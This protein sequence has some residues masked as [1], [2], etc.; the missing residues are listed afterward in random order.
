[1]APGDLVKT[2]DDRVGVIIQVWPTEHGWDECY[3]SFPTQIVE[4]D[5]PNPPV[6]EMF[7]T[8]ELQLHMPELSQEQMDQILERSEK[9]TGWLTQEELMASLA[10]HQEMLKTR[11]DSREAMISD[12]NDLIREVLR[13]QRSE[14]MNLNFE[15]KEA[16]YLLSEASRHLG[17]ASAHFSKT[18]FPNP[19]K[20]DKTL[21]R[22]SLARVSAAC[23]WAIK[24]LS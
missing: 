15:E 14:V 22:L 5:V 11:R 20:H 18:K 1:M 12:L 17:Q 24:K 19:R 23:G 6:V 7:R 2:K 21:T 4:E 9:E 3:A 10:E 13:K 8:A 16:E